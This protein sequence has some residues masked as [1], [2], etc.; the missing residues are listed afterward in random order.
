MIPGI[1]RRS[2]LLTDHSVVGIDYLFV[3]PGTQTDLY[4][5][6]ISP[7]TAAQQAELTAE[8]MSITASDGDAPDV[9]IDTVS[10][11]V[12]GTEVV[13][14]VHTA[15][16]GGFT[17]Y[18][19][20]IQNPTG[21]PVLDPYLA[22]IE[23]SFKAGCYSDIDCKHEGHGCPLDPSVDFAVDYEARDFWSLRTALL[24][25]ASQRYPGWSDRLEAD[26]GTMLL[27]IMAAL[28]DESAYYQ[29][30]IAREAYLET[31]TQRRSLRR[32]ARFVDYRI[33]DGAG[34][35]TW[36]DVTAKTAGTLDA[37]TA[38]YAERDGVRVSFSIGRDLDEMITTPPTGFAISPARNAERLIP[39]AWDA[40]DECLELGATSMFLA[41]GTT[42]YN[43]LFP[44]DD[45][46]EGRPAGRWLLLYSEPVDPSR[47]S[48]RHLVRVTG[49][50][51]VRDPLAQDDTTEIQWEPQQ[52]LPFEL[53]LD[54]LQVH[55]NIVP[56]VA[57]RY[58]E[59]PFRIGEFNENR[60][61]IAGEPFAVEREG[62][63]ASVTYLSSLPSTETEGLVRRRSKAIPDD[64]RQTQPELR[65]VERVPDGLGGLADGDQW[66]W[67]SS[68]LNAEAATPT[69]QSFALDDGTWR[70]VVGYRRAGTVV[71]H[72]DYA[73]DDGSTIRFGDGQFGRIPVRGTRFL[74]RY[75][76]GNGEIAN[77]PPGALSGFDQ[78]IPATDTAVKALI[79]S[80]DNPLAVVGGAE[81]EAADDIRALAPEAFR[82]VNFRAVRPADYAEAVER[83]PWVQRAGCSFRWTG[84]WQTAF[85]TPDPRASVELSPAQRADVE[86]QLD[87][88]R[89]A[90]QDAQALAPRYADLDVRITFCART[91]FYA[92]QVKRRVAEVLE[93]N[94]D[95]F[96]SPDRFSFGTWLDRS[97]L[98]AT[99]QS[100]P[101]VKA[102]VSVEFRRRGVF[103]WRELVGSYRPA[104][105]EVIRVENDARHPDRGS[106]ELYAEGGA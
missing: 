21:S 85:V 70:R 55:G 5:H 8:R 106:F 47:P 27:E 19:L 59:H 64:L 48:R 43:A 3:D 36:L 101:G 81:P 93:A 53:R 73:L 4:V 29:D 30:R 79:T 33:H 89:Q 38:V 16:P 22:E 61:A 103:D 35:H 99:V 42:T 75:L 62:P 49:A 9:R 50:R 54:D 26:A 58:C 60:I 2:A 97:Q 24:D 63:G 44:F 14:L 74:A 68:L 28:G 100:V 67:R 90:G 72:I 82:A 92:D 87:R 84:S 65:L 66:T 57:G 25:F 32:H 52:A 83:L 69:D 39:Y 95:G 80:I 71:E 56:A 20:S 105:D 13:L 12:V 7:P 31:A 37:G 11:P 91:D 104:R 34:A 40:A 96:F 15:T 1:D 88:F 17:T 46:T 86:R 94:A 6:F 98:E 76:V 102:V 51:R 18:T 41:G 23:F 77:L 10:F 78:S 45:A